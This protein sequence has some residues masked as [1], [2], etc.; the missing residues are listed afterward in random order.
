MSLYDYEKNTKYL[1]RY[2]WFQRDLAS[3]EYQ[4]LIFGNDDV[5]Y[6]YWNTLNLDL[7]HF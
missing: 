5:R 7:L 4:E 3:T 6:S 1:K 2:E